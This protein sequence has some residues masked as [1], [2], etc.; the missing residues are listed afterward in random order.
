MAKVRDRIGDGV[1][2]PEDV[3]LVEVSGLG[4]EKSFSLK[5]STSS[6]AE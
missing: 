6:A 5:S 4:V 1:E 3:T 2:E